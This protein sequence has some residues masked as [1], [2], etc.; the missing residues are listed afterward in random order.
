MIPP[1]SS[2]RG[3]EQNDTPL[4]SD[5]V[6]SFLCTVA[7]A[8]CYLLLGF[9]CPCCLFVRGFTLSSLYHEAVYFLLLAC[10]AAYFSLLLSSHVSDILPNWALSLCVAQ[11]IGWCQ[12]GIRWTMGSAFAAALAHRLPH[13]RRHQAPAAFCD[14]I[15]P[16]FF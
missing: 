3:S 12:A 14:P 9:P 8:I 10:L 13:R 1:K 2:T 4:S 16:L 11:P 6:I 5:L 7:C 15:F